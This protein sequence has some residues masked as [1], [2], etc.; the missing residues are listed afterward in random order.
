[1]PTQNDALSKA[2]HIQL[3][4]VKYFSLAYVIIFATIA[5][6]KD[7]F[8]FLFYAILGLFAIWYVRNN[9]RELYF[10][11]TILTLISIFGF[12]H[13]LAG[14]LYIN[15]IKLYDTWFLGGLI[16]F[17]NIVH[18]FGGALAG[19][20]AYNFL[21]NHLYKKMRRST[22]AT[23]FLI[24]TLASGFGAF[25]ELIEFFAVIYFDAAEAVGDYTNTA[26]D[27]VY[28]FIGGLI[29]ATVVVLYRR[30]NKD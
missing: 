6:M 2:T 17:D 9:Y 13:L 10:T 23:F 28:N 1:M 27:I 18:C 21:S 30:Q 14:Q 7:N 12:T 5:V 25:N 3:N 20:V 22:F 4:L 29:A 24:I 26:V 16:K 15:G 19:F 11:K 8:E